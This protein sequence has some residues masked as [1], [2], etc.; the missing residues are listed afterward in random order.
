MQPF[1]WDLASE[2]DHLLQVLV[3]DYAGFW[4]SFLL[5]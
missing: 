2:H 5:G 3:L 1:E 4:W